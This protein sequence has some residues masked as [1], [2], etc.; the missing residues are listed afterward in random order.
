ML[1]HD[2][3]GNLRYFY[4]DN[5]PVKYC[6]THSRNSQ[7]E[8]MDTVVAQRKIRKR[9][10]TKERQVGLNPEGGAE[11]VPPKDHVF[12]PLPS[13]HREIIPPHP[14]PGSN[15]NGWSH[16][17]CGQDSQ[18]PSDSWA[19]DLERSAQ[20]SDCFMGKHLFTMRCRRRQSDNTA[21]KKY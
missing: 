4:H 3:R 11:S 19:L 13:V 14:S 16:P 5:Q 8:T 1:N 18:I 6:N 12:L 15:S 21:G 2:E 17:Q 7:I 10:S 9:C 20:G